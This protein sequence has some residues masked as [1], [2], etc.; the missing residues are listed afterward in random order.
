MREKLKIF[1][2]ASLCVLAVFIIYSWIQ[3]I[4]AGEEGRVR[5]FIMQGKKAVESKNLLACSDLVSFD[6][7][8]KYG[9]DRQSLLFAAKGIFD[10]YEDIVVHIEKMDI[11]LDGSKTQ[12]NVELVALVI[13]RS[14]ENKSENIIEGLE[15]EKGR[16]RVKLIKVDKRWL[17]LEFE[18]FESLH[19]MGQEIT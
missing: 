10:Y 8:D 7:R 12:A 14:K 19:L 5:K 17:L 15:G 6:Y 13:G 9:N 16:I 11:K 2:L 1:I 3:N 18:Y 4:I